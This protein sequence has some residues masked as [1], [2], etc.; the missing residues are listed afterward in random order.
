MFDTLLRPAPKVFAGTPH[1]FSKVFAASHYAAMLHV[2]AHAL[3]GPAN[4][5]A[6]FLH[7]PGG[8][9]VILL[10]KAIQRG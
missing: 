8:G 5:C 10:S 7:L 3:A 2:S 4:L 9:V 6:A 1:V